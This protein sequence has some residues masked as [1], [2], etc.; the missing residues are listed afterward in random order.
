MQNNNDE[1]GRNEP[2]SPSPPP[3]SQ[4]QDTDDSTGKSPGEPLIVPTKTH[5]GGRMNVHPTANGGGGQLST[6]TNGGGGGSRSETVMT[7][8]SR[9]DNFQR[10]SDIDTRMNTLL[11]LEPVS[12]PNEGEVQEDWRQLTGFQGLG[13]R[14]RQPRNNDDHGAEEEVDAPEEVANGNRE[15]TTTP[16]RTRLSWEV[17]MSALENMWM[18]RGELDAPLQEP[19]PPRVEPRQEQQRGSGGENQN[20]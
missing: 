15:T 3:P 18:Q 12:N 11:G 16:R 7:T 10:Y 2:P 19:D 8:T 17:H 5:D 1:N 13:R 4:K 6:N 9:P 20:E 14:R